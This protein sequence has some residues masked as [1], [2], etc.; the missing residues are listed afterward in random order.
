MENKEFNAINKMINVL[1]MHKSLIDYYVTDIGIHR[2]QHRILMYLSGKNCLF[3]Q[4]ELSVHLGISPAGVTGALRKLEADGYIKRC[5][6]TDNRYNEIKIT[7]M[8]KNVVERTKI[9]FNQIDRELFSD[10]SD[11]ELN[12]YNKFLDRLCLNAENETKI[13]RTNK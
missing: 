10:F 4:K 11:E 6:G 13:R 2:T 12:A 1:K 5:I 3:S 9:T 7:E 8:G